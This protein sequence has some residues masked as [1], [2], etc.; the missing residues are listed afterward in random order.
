[1]TKCVISLLWVLF[2]VVTCRIFNGRKNGGNKFY[3]D[4][5][6]VINVQPGGAPL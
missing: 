4:Y 5:Q 3:T 2:L 6:N 1:M